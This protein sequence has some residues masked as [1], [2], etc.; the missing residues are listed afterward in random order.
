MTKISIV[1]ITSCRNCIHKE[2]DQDGWY[3]CGQLRKQGR[4]YE[5]IKEYME[6][7]TFHPDCPLEDKK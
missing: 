6:N 4:L 5:S 3:A 7:E 1:E 2:Y